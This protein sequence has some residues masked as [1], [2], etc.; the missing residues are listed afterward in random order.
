MHY[1]KQFTLIRTGLE[2]MLDA[3]KRHGG[4]YFFPDNVNVGVF[5]LSLSV[6][7]YIYIYMHPSLSK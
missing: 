3:Q 7:I 6:Y 2:L 5:S 4:G 1:E